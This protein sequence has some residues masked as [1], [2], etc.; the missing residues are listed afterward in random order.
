MDE[1]ARRLLL[2]AARQASGVVPDGLAADLLRADSVSGPAAVATANLRKIYE[3]LRGAAAAPA[4]D[5]QVAIRRPRSLGLD[6]TVVG[7]TY[8]APATSLLPT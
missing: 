7:L 6:T 1:A 2:E 4:G 8:L 5:R 3:I